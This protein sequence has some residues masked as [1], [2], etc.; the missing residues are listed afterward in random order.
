[1]YSLLNQLVRGLVREDLQHH[2]HYHLPRAFRDLYKD[3]RSDRYLEIEDLNTTFLDILAESKETYIIIDALDECPEEKDRDEVI[4]FLAELSRDASNSTHI[5]ITSRREEDI[6]SAIKKTLGKECIVPI[7][8]WQVN[9][10]VRRH[11]EKCM[12]EDPRFKT[13]NDD[14]KMEVIQDLTKRTD[15]VFRWVDCQLVELRK[16]RRPFDIQEVL[17]E[18]PKDLDETYARMLSQIDASRY[19]NEACVVLKWLAFS[20]RPLKLSEAA[21]AVAFDFTSDLSSGP[22]VVFDHRRKFPKLL[23][24][25]AILSGLVTVSGLDDGFHPDAEETGTYQDGVITFA[26]FSVR[27][28][29]ECGRANPTFTRQWSQSHRFILESCLG[30]ILHYDAKASK[31]SASEE[32][33]PLLRYA[34]QYWSYHATKL[35]CDTDL[36]MVQGY[37]NRLIEPLVK[38]RGT[39]FILSTRVALRL[40]NDQSDERLPN[41]LYNLLKYLKGEELAFDFDNYSALHSASEMGHKGLVRLLL[42]GGLDVNMR[43]EDNGLSA[44][45]VAA[46]EGQDQVARLLMEQ[47]ADVAAKDKNGWTALHWASRNGSKTVT[48][49]LLE[50]GAD[51]KAQDNNRRTPL[52]LAVKQ[53]HEA[54]VLLLAAQGKG[55]YLEIRDV[56]GLTALHLAVRVAEWRGEA[57]ETMVKL[58]LQAGASPNVHSRSGKTA[59]GEAAE[60]ERDSLVQLLENSEAYPEAQTRQ[61][62]TPRRGDL[63]RLWKLLRAVISECMWNMGEG[64]D[65]K[66]VR[67]TLKKHSEY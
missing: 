27:E 40:K 65:M 2:H 50:K 14:I 41:V 30:Y 36:N 17:K 5:L 28:Y 53:G 38:L 35:C 59:L 55:V 12:A 33:Y 57:G 24:F 7:Q 23:D 26:H 11:L 25:R 22:S 44:L 51:F 4:K 16:C 20:K 52:H 49:I 67:Y 43:H 60:Y 21:E 13:W 54:V 48:K 32:R 61:Q 58:L 1:M 18:L 34:C 46:K 42:D 39:A 66:K 15:G 8:N 45:H 9:D 63:G 10:D 31:E 56:L 19:K 6:E 62:I 37:F 29:L 47:G 64:L 3:K